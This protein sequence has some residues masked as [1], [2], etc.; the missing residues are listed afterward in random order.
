MK[1]SK[2]ITVIILIFTVGCAGTLPEAGMP[3]KPVKQEQKQEQKATNPHGASDEVM[4]LLGL[5]A[6][7]M[8]TASLGVTADFAEDAP[9][10]ALI[11]FGTG[12]IFWSAA[13]ITYLVQDSQEESA[14]PAPAPPV[15]PKKLEEPPSPADA[16]DD[17]ENAPAP[18]YYEDIYEENKD[19]QKEEKTP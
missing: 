18:E 4:V 10:F 14:K 16:P 11:S 8:M 2:L 6:I 3:D 9:E 1:I 19:N 15:E 7:A 13:G 5:G 17:W 12:L